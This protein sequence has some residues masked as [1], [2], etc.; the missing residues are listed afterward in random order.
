M[1]KIN[2]QAIVSD[3]QKKRGTSS[4]I[5]KKPVPIF[6]PKELRVFF[7][8]VL[9]KQI[10][11][12]LVLSEQGEKAINI[13]CMYLNNEPGFEEM[14][15]SFQK[16]LWLAGEYG[17]GKT[18]LIKAYREAKLVLFGETVGFK[19]CVQM[20]EEYLRLNEY[21]NKHEGLKA[22]SAYAN[23]YD[24]HER[25]FDDLGEEETT[26]NDYGNKTCVMAKILSERYK[27]FPNTTTHI[28]TNLGS[29]DIARD[30]GGRIES[31]V[32]E[33]FNFIPLGVGE[34]Y[35]DIRKLK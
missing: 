18:A 23:R 27:G 15:Y 30:Y 9:C 12:E 19:T 1:E 25:I 14:G 4:G 13:I 35:I 20:N 26:V 33:M 28:T 10:N 22:I 11:R 17:T 6:K 2:I 24:T 29:K 31:R 8:E 7:I 21:T 16:G 32:Y 34:D 3:V 5:T